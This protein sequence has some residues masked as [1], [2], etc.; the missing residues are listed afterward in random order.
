MVYLIQKDEHFK[1]LYEH[2]EGK[3]TVPPAKLCSTIG[4]L[5]KNLSLKWLKNLKNHDPKSCLTIAII[6]ILKY[7]DN[8]DASVRVIAYSTLG[9]ML[10]CVAT[11]DPI[12]FIHAFG[13]AT[14]QTPISPRPSMGIINMFVY[15]SRFV[16]SVQLQEFIIVVPVVNHFNADVSDFLKYLPQ[17]IPLMKNL[18]S[19]FHQCFLKTL[20]KLCSKRLNSS[21]T[22]AVYSLV[23]LNKPLLVPFLTN[24][25]SDPSL[26]TAVVYLGPTLIG[27][28]EIYDILTDNGRELFLAAALKEF[29]RDPPG[30]TEFEAS[31]ITC[32]HFLRYARKTDQYEALHSRIFA[33]L[34]KDYQPHFRRLRMLLPMSLEDILSIHEDTDSMK[35]AQILAITSY[36]LDNVETTDSDQI[37]QIFLSYRFTRNDLY[38]SLIESLSKCINLFLSNCKEHYHIKL[39][40]WILKKNNINWVHDMAVANLLGGIDC[41]LCAKIIPEFF[42]LACERL[43]VFSL[44]PNNRLFSASIAAIKHIVSYDTLHDLLSTIIRC[45]W[46]DEFNVSRRFEL[47]STLASIFNSDEFQL[48]VPIA[49]ECI[50]FFGS[51][52]VVSNACVFLSKIKVDSIPEDIRIFCL[53]FIAS[54]FESFT[55]MPINVPVQTFVSP[56]PGPNFLDAIDTDIVTN[57]VFDQETAL[58]PIR[59]CFHL[60]CLIPLKSL[61]E[62]EVFFWYCINLVPLFPQEALEKAFEIQSFKNVNE[63]ILWKVLYR[64]FK[65][66]SSDSVTA[67]CCKLLSRSI[68]DIPPNVDVM[69][70]KYLIEQ[71]SKD[72]DLLY[73]VFVLVDQL[74]HDKAI[75]SVPSLVKGLDH[76]IASVLLFKLVLVIGREMVMTIADKYAIALLQYAN[77]YGGEYTEKVNKYIESTSFSEWPLDDD[78]MNAEL[79]TFL[80][81]KQ[82]TTNCK[83]AVGDYSCLD[84]QHLMFLVNYQELFQLDGFKEFIL[85]NPSLFFKIDTS[86]IFIKESRQTFKFKP[87]NEKAKLTIC[88]IS[89]FLKKGKC[90]KFVNSEN[91]IRNDDDPTIESISSPEFSSSNSFFDQPPTKCNS[92]EMLMGLLDSFFEFSNIKITQKQFDTI[93]TTKIYRNSTFKKAISYAIKN[94]LEINLSFVIQHETNFF[95]DDDLFVSFLSYLRTRYSSINRIDPQ[96]RELI[97][98]KLEKKIEP[99]QIIGSKWRPS[100]RELVLLD[101]NSFLNF[102]IEQT[103]FKGVQFR[104]L[105]NLLYDASFDAVVLHDIIVKYLSVFDG[106]ESV[107]KKALL[108]RFIAATIDSLLKKKMKIEAGFIIGFLNASLEMILDS[109][110]SAMHQELAYLFKVIVPVIE[111]PG[112]YVALIE[113]FMRETH[114]APLFLRVM[115]LLY[116]AHQ[117]QIIQINLFVSLFESEVPSFS[118]ISLWCLDQIAAS[119]APPLSI[120]IINGCQNNL[121]RMMASLAIEYSDVDVIVSYVKKLFSNPTIFHI[122]KL[123]FDSFCFTFL[124]DAKL[125]SFSSAVEII[126]AIFDSYPHPVDALFNLS[127]YSDNIGH[128]FVD[129]FKSRKKDQ[130]ALKAIND[131]ICS[132]FTFHPSISLAKIIF[133]TALDSNSVESTVFLL[134]NYLLHLDNF[135]LPYFFILRLF[136]TKYPKLLE[137]F[138][139]IFNGLSIKSRS[140]SLLLSISDKDDD[141]IKSFLYAASESNDIDLIETEYNLFLNNDL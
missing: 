124:S 58:A 129:I 18:P 84:R 132:F 30:F 122:E 46:I 76:K 123:F 31:C 133:N 77:F 98:K 92:E 93:F 8:P 128:I 112:Q 1:I 72:P 55:Q 37:S 69:V 17:I 80:T 116:K 54:N 83:Q 106:F 19:S 104:S 35:A 138:R 26:D 95:K 70:E 111:K 16:S 53:N 23:C 49:F 125:P 135:F 48:F 64:T 28:R 38:C 52:N 11:F 61:K 68:R 10:L 57:P 15:L 91:S 39:L 43:L 114:F 2:Q 13:N 94:Y 34:K 101:P 5:R 4:S 65:T 136:F 88:T 14:S 139:D 105:I 60:C 50:L 119:E 24:I 22:V 59:N 109:P 40:K 41:Y 99:R 86:P 63:D 110:F 9:A 120:Q 62:I 25:V 33:K 6:T 121:A 71:R 66:S 102:F 21:F 36:Y 20:L 134:M 107:K 82:K 96:I 97:E 73:Y 27:D 127:F 29:V 3:V 117:I 32:S 103:E 108:I 89:P 126:P 42:K 78:G 141:V 7:T 12:L 45:D 85:Q 118:Q 67:T 44:S 79:V 113:K 47:L 130:V 51:I 131:R 56:P 115:T 90:A 140:F 100:L 74:Q 81:N 87:I 75:Q 137:S